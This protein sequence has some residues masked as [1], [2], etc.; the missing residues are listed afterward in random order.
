MNA[1][2]AALMLECQRSLRSIIEDLSAKNDALREQA[3]KSEE[4]TSSL[5]KEVEQLKKE[6]VDLTERVTAA[7]REKTDMEKEL[8][9]MRT[10]KKEMDHKM[11]LLEQGKKRDKEDLESKKKEVKT[12]QVTGSNLLKKGERLDLKK[13]PPQ[14]MC[15]QRPKWTILRVVKRAEIGIQ[16]DK[17]PRSEAESRLKDLEQANTRLNHELATLKADKKK[18]EESSRA[19]IIRLQSALMHKDAE[20]GAKRRRIIPF[21]QQVSHPPP[22][23]LM[24][25]NNAPEY[26]NPRRQWNQPAPPHQ[27]QY[28]VRATPHQNGPPPAQ[29]AGFYV[30][31]YVG[32]PSH[33]GA[34]YT[35]PPLHQVCPR[36]PQPPVLGPQTSSEQHDDRPS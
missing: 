12:L 1:D 7:E 13:N 6:K 19:T 29:G 31:R 11:V 21:Q 4:A 8:V 17:E 2:Q 23:I 3:Q 10:D 28:F 16:T 22:R 30:N 34:P 24:V 32:R 15:V 27:S 5:A 26:R 33:G 25:P 9:Q 14:E 18:F 36:P 35:G 20:L